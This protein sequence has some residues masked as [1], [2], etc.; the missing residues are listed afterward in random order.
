MY[1]GVAATAAFV[2]GA[3]VAFWWAAL[4]PPW[5]FVFGT[6]LT[7]LTVVLVALVATASGVVLGTRVLRP[8]AA[9]WL[10]TA[11]S[12]ATLAV[13]FGTR[14]TLPA[15]VVTVIIAVV[16]GL[17]LG[18]VLAVASAVGRGRPVLIVV[19]LIAGFV[20]ATYVY[21]L[22][23]SLGHGDS[24]LLT[25][26]AVLAGI[27]ALADS[28][29]AGSREQAAS[30]W[31]SI[32][33][34]GAM[35]VGV[36]LIATMRFSLLET[37]LYNGAPSPRRT[38]VVGS[39]DRFAVIAA[40]AVMA[41]LVAAFAYRVG[42]RALARWVIVAVSLSY[43]LA[44]V[45]LL[46]PSSLALAV[47]VSAVSALVGAAAAVRADRAAPWDAV[48]VLLCG[49]TAFLL[50]TTGQARSF[51]TPTGLLLLLTGLLAFAAGAGVAGAVRG[52]ASAGGVVTSVLLG[53]SALV[54]S[55]ELTQALFPEPDLRYLDGYPIA[56]PVVMSGAA[57]VLAL[58]WG[59]G[60]LVERVRREIRDEAAR[61]AA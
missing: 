42:G 26:A 45:G 30:A 6:R 13:L 44:S 5:A 29:P 49:W 53:L 35:G 32:L 24:A 47:L 43:P 50:A 23:L 36:W 22:A 12:F 52:R 3:V 7:D 4:A 15:G 1:A 2:S 38:E 39:F 60:R 55:L 19:P 56:I 51:D 33:V 11:A 18:G 25:S 40:P 10:V 17:A 37:L 57:V 61:S 31:S 8:G 9:G 27:A 20:S 58:L 34:I 41:L 28:R 46:R 59:M 21:S 14:P 54:F 16:I 48:S